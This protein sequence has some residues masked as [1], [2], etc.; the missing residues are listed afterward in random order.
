MQHKVRGRSRRR[1]IAIVAAAVLLA[2]LVWGI[3]GAFAASSSP[4]PS[5]G[6]VVLKLGWTNN[7][8]NLNPF[9][10]YTAS[11]YEVWSLNY[12]LLCGFRASDMS[13]NVQ[14]QDAP[15][16][17]TA[18]NHSADGLTW[19]FTIRSGVKW[20]DGQPLTASDVAF[21]FNYIIQNS[22]ANYTS[23]TK[24]IKSV[25]APNATTVVFHCTKPK[26]NMTALWIPI[27]PEHVWKSV[28]GDVAQKSYAMP[29][30]I[31]GSGPFYVSAWKKNNYVQL[32][33]NPYYWRAKPAVDEILFQTYTNSDTMSAD[34]QSGALDAGVGLLQGQYRALKGQSGLTTMA[35]ESVGF[36]EIGF[37]CYTGGPSLGNPVLKD[38]K[39]RQ[40]LQWAVDKHE[41]NTIAYGGL[42]Q[43]ADTIIN[44]NYFHNPDWH[45]TPPADQ[46]YSFDL[47]KAG[48][49]LTAAGY[50]LKNGVRVDK[51]GKPIV[52]RMFTRSEDA[53]TISVG[54]LVVGWFGQIGIKV[55]L[56]SLD[57][58][59]LSSHIYNSKNGVFTPDYD[60]FT[61]DWGGD[62]DPN[63]ILS[64]FTTEQINN[65]SDCA[66]SNPQYDAL[67][68]QQQAALDPNQR[69]TI[70][71]QMQQI[72]YQ[73]TPYI[74]TVYSHDIV[75]YNTAKW[76][77]WVRAPAGI[78][79]VW[80]TTVPDS[81]IYLK[82]VA[83]TKSSSNTTLI[84][85]IVAAVIA[86]IVI[87]AVVLM[88][89]RSHRAVEE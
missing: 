39:F 17:A 37:N 42:A 33:R 23:Y 78:G 75:A 73:E 32:E 3:A 53:S 60:M 69:K 25:E 76:T 88:R 57:D 20:S 1:V 8:D 29:M 64:V 40:A 35:Y 6:K 12:D 79:G 4:S 9:I 65:W 83:G 82:P 58:D 41:I 63:F 80:Y 48:D 87:I 77:G 26:A 7:P 61:W 10:G 54:K 84:L 89:G 36:E 49:A 67:F 16:L 13:S 43:S 28:P 74:I 86:V 30:P 44:A 85:I 15:G 71:D 45:W 27:L 24:F 18:W 70:I 2:V 72:V 46:A 62:I 14:G 34:L 81:Y 51:A 66:W 56:T 11:A 22:E 5:S 31:V 47:T 19:T 68:A 21:T 52:L 55:V 38:W 50:P 59:T